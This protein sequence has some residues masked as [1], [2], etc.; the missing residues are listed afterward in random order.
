MLC[1]FR[2]FPLITPFPFSAK[3]V[4][5]YTLLPFLTARFFICSARVTRKA[6]VRADDSVAGYHERHGI[7]PHSTADRLRRSSFSRF[8]FDTL[9]YFPIKT[10]YA[11]SP[12][13]VKW[14]GNTKWLKKMWKGKLD[15]MVRRLQAQ[16]VKNTPYEDKEWRKHK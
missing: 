6:S 12:T 1:S 10:Y 11:V 15:K 5:K 2:K 13:L 14:F 9:R 3:S 4:R 7:M 16:G 8:S